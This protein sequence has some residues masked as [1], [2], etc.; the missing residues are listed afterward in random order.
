[1]SN[2]LLNMLDG[3]RKKFERINIFYSLI[4]AENMK[5]NLT[6]IRNEEEFYFDCVYEAVFLTKSGLVDY[7]AMDL[8]SGAGLPGIL[9][10]IIDSK[11][12]ILAES[13]KN[14]AEF[15]KRAVIELSLDNVCVF[16][17]RGE[18]YL[19]ENRVNTIVAK[20]VGPLDRVFRWIRKCST[21]NNL[22]LLKG[23][24]WEKEEKKLLE[25]QK[26]SGIK[27]SNTHKYNVGARR[28]RER[29]FIKLVR[30]PGR[31]TE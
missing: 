13:E 11:Q 6:R 20:A 10:A 1:M 18:E 30:D 29:V 25:T 28:D 22:I 3:D 12:W 27:I 7:P 4:Q 31:L 9:C 2:D 19:R 26:C 14:K 17:G 16:Y 8:G 24:K 5:Q 23:P 21:W 15:L